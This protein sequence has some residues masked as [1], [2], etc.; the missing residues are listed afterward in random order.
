VRSLLRVSRGP[1]ERALSEVCAL[2]RAL[3]GE[4]E[5]DVWSSA[6]VR[7]QWE[8]LRVLISATQLNAA[9]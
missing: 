6:E 7:V 9:S 8:V 2:I 4:T 3:N 5:D 1:P